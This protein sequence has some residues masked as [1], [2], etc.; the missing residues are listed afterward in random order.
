MVNVLLAIQAR[1]ASTRLPNKVML[2]LGGKPIIDHVINACKKSLKYMNNYS[3]KSKINVNMCIVIPEGDKLIHYLRDPIVVGPEED[4]ITRYKNAMEKYTPDYLVRITGDCPM[5][6]SYLITKAIN[7]AVKGEYDFLSNAHPNLRT[8]ADGH[9]VEVCNKKLFSWLDKT[10]Q[11]REHVF[12]ILYE[13]VYPEWRIGH[14]F[15]YIDLSSV[16]LSVDTEKDYKLVKK[17]FDSRFDKIS[18]WKRM[19]GENTANN[20]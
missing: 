8:F 6:P 10:S 11:E 7:C 13:N 9:D 2:P 20:F 15:S 19:Y 1:S 5:I 16:K 12:Q 18:K 3:Q 17:Q 4:L 14:I